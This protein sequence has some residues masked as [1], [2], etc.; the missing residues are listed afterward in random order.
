MQ[1]IEIDKATAAAIEDFA[2]TFDFDVSRP[3]AESLGYD[4]VGISFTVTN[5]DFLQGNITV[6]VDYSIHGACDGYAY[7]EPIWT[8]DDYSIDGIYAQDNDTGDDVTITNKKEF[9]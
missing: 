9:V 6:Y 5:E 7:G 4:D 2:E 8:V 1:T 3:N